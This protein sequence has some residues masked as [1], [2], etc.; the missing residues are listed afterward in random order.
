MHRKVL[1][2]YNGINFEGFWSFCVN[3]RTEKFNYSK[4]TPF[5]NLQNFVK[6]NFT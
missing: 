6:A 2:F 4:I 3:F 5:R 1:L